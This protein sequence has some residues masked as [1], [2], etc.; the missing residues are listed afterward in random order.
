MNKHTYTTKQFIITSIILFTIQFIWD[1]YITS[2]YKISAVL[3]LTLLYL[4]IAGI[5]TSL[6]II[7][8]TVLLAKIDNTPLRILFWS[9]HS[10]VILLYKLI[11]AIMYSIVY[12]KEISTTWAI[13]FIT[14]RMLLTALY[15][16]SSFILIMQQNNGNSRAV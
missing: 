10:T 1:I 13:I 9:I 5:F 14:I 15:I 8:I 3:S 2:L 6:I 12:L 4:G 11:F 7:L 16:I